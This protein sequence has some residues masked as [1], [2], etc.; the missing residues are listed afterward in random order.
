MFLNTLS[1]QGRREEK[2]RRRGEQEKKRKR[3]EEKR[4]RQ[5][6]KKSIFIIPQQLAIFSGKLR[7]LVVL[8]KGSTDISRGV[9]PTLATPPASKS[10]ILRPTPDEIPYTTANPLPQPGCRLLNRIGRSSA[11]SDRGLNRIGRSIAISDRGLNRIEPDR[12][13]FR[14]F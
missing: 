6:E 3:R 11:I 2:T 9:R 1:L 5:K 4:R 13:S 10:P 12:L 14:G 7:V 8:K